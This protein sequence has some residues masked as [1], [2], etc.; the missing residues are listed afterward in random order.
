MARSLRS[1]Q[2]SP[3]ILRMLRRM[4]SRQNQPGGLLKGANSASSMCFEG[5]MT[6]SSVNASCRSRK[7]TASS[8]SPAGVSHAP[9]CTNGTSYGSQISS[10]MPCTSSACVGGNDGAPS[11]SVGGW[12]MAKKYGV[13]AATISPFSPTCR[14]KR[15]RSRT[16]TMGIRFLPLPRITCSWTPRQASLKRGV[17]AFSPSPYNTPPPTIKALTDE[18]SRLKQLRTKFSISFHCSYFEPGFGVRCT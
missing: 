18:P 6:R 10:T 9:S 13:S 4:P 17:N 2:N 12:S 5:A 14:T 16:W 7:A 3:A 1:L 15:A 11:G 8:S